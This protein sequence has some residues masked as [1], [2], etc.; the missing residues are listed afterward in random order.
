MEGS[1]GHHAPAFMIAFI[2]HSQK[3]RT[4]VMDST[5]VVVR[6]WGERGCNYKDRTRER[7]FL[8]KIEPYTDCDGGFTHTYMC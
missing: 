1:Q 6:D 5:S 3:D 2:W 8:G 4:V 7:V